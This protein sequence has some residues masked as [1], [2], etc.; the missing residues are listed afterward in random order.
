MASSDPGLL[1]FVPVLICLGCHSKITHSLGD[2]N[3]EMY[4][5]TVSEAG[6]PDQGVSGFGFSCPEAFLLACGWLSSHCGFTG[7]FLQVPSLRHTAIRGQWSHVLP[8]TF[9]GLCKSC[10]DLLPWMG[11][12]ARMRGTLLTF[13]IDWPYQICST[14]NTLPVPERGMQRQGA[15]CPIPAQSDELTSIQT[16]VSSMAS[17][18]VKR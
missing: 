5:L 14:E 12:S 16:N 3:T 10:S 6:S 11:S 4:F 13:L 8:N 7:P 1:I 17:F 15:L 2:L 9:P 18:A